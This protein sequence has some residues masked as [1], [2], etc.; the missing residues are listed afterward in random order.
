[1]LLALLDREEGYKI[2]GLDLYVQVYDD[3]LCRELTED[4]VKKAIKDTS[5]YFPAV[6]VNGVTAEE[7]TTEEEMRTTP[8]VFVTTEENFNAI[9]VFYPDVLAKI[10]KIKNSSLLFGFTSKYEAVVHAVKDTNVEEIKEAIKYTND[11]VN[12][13]D[14]IL[15]YDVFFYSTITGEIT[16]M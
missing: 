9:A 3:L 7:I 14:E 12:N 6:F 11:T 5:E 1:M 2:D 16:K 13:D 10:A 8:F 4:I 15:S